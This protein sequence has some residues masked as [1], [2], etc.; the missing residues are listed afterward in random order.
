[1]NTTKFF[2]T[3]ERYIAFRNAFRKAINNPRAK[4]GKPDENGHRERGWIR[5]AH[6]MLQNIIRDLPYDR[7]FTP[8]TKQVRLDNGACPTEAVINAKWYLQRHINDAKAYVKAEPA[9]LSHW[10]LPKRSSSLSD[11]WKSADKKEQENS[12]Y[13]AA[14]HKLIVAKTAN[15]QAHLLKRVNAFLEPFSDAFTIQDLA[16]VEIKEAKN[17]ADIDIAA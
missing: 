14:I 1:M 8:I 11:M 2:E 12:E 6:M 10:E 3:K 4:K 16:R 5:A 15:Q 9:Q 17:E 7:G 13:Q